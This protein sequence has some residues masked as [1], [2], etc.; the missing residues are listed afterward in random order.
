MN[1]RVDHLLQLITGHLDV[2]NCQETIKSH[3]DQYPV[4]NVAQTFMSQG[5]TFM[6][7]PIKWQWRE[8]H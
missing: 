8:I 6:S 5:G 2:S 4:H 3:L 1:L 7:Q